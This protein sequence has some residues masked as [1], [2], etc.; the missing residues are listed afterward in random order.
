MKLNY[1]SFLGISLLGALLLVGGCVLTSVYP[2]YMAKDVVFDAKLAG[3]WADADKPDKTDEFW[4]FSW[5]ATNSAY[6]L[7]VH[8]GD[9]QT[10]FTARLFRLKQWTFIDALPTA[11]C[12]EFVPPHYLLKVM[13]FEPT[14][15]LAALDYKWVDNLLDEKPGALRHLRVGE[16]EKTSGRLVLT[17]NTAEL[18]KFILKHVADTNAFPEV[19]NFSRRP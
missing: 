15:K 12:G 3:R 19:Y 16:D 9:K 1:K 7:V 11:E 5:V 8:N 13:H 6:T 10:E 14:L 18:Q 17:A 2:Y 4:E